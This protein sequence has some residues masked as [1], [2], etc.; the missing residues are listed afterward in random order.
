MISI[1]TKTDLLARFQATP[2]DSAIKKDERHAAV[3]I[4]FW[5]DGGDLSLCI[6]R[7]A[8]HPL[9]PWS[10]DMAFPGGKAECQDSSLHDVASRETFE[11]VGLILPPEALIGRIDK[12]VA[13]SG[14]RR[15]QTPVWPL[16]YLIESQPA[17]FQLSDEMTE[18]H[19]VP[20]VDL[21]DR[22][23]WIAFSFPA[24]RAQYPG[25]NIGNHFFWGF[26]LR[27]LIALSEQLGHSLRPILALE[28]VSHF[29]K[30]SSG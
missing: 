9:D 24:T 6:G 2:A 27:V 21:W 22:S 23:N 30:I 3:A 10:G 1:I 16:I 13:N 20:V 17:P 7:R 19:W 4:V 11:E 25:I 15:N 8:I 28:N 26:S 14:A 18:A 29:E 12:M 5:N